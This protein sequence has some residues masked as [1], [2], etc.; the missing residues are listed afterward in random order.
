MSETRT[1]R[2]IEDLIDDEVIYDRLTMIF[3]MLK[4]GRFLESRMAPIKC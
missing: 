3:D 4:I 2:W 1:V